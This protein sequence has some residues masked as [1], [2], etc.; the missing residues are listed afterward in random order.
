VAS[1]IYQKY[2]EALL[3]ALANTDLNDGDVRVI[4]VDAAD[5]TFS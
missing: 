5:Y 1:A 3:D 4:L 2:K